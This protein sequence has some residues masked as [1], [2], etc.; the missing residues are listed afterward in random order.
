MSLSI[1]TVF[2]FSCPYCYLVWGYIRK[3]QQ[4]VSFNVEWMTWE[5]HP[6]VPIEGQDIREV[7]PDVSLEGRLL[8]LNKLGAPVG[9]EP[10]SKV[11][12][13]NTRLAL[14][15]VEFA[16][17]NHKL[18]EWID[19]VFQGSFAENRDIG[20]IAVL[21]DI[22]GGIG[23]DV[24]ELRQALESGRYNGILL[25]HDQACAKRQVE[26]VPTIFVGN[27]KI[28]EG[29]FTFDAFEEAIRSRTGQGN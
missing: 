26:W 11:F 13:P 5:I 29:A 18:Q 21:L 12:V 28:L 8:K 4:E 3:S 25:E 20:D 1:N 14:Q 22:A 2:D 16:R 27:D 17:E 7:V 9:L 23:L 10:G 19:A 15:T 24:A 6:D